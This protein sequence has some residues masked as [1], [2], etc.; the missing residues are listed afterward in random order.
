VTGADPRRLPRTK[1]LFIGGEGRSGSTVLERLLATDPQTCAV[2][3]AKYLFERGIGSGELCGCGRPVPECELWSVVGDRLVGG[4]GSPEG[5]DLVQF[6]TALD[7]PRN[8]PAVVLGRGAR[9]RR[10]RAVL[11]ELYPLIAEVSGCE[12]IID[13]SKHPAWAYLLAGTDTVDLRVVHLVRHPSGVVQSWS[14]SVKRPQ[15]DKGSGDQLMA[16]QSPVEVALR[17]DIFNRLYHRLGRRSVPTVLVR[18]EDY[19]NDLEGTL[20][21]CF[22]LFGLPYMSAPDGM[23]NGHGIAGNPSRFAR[24][25]EKITQDDR[26][27]TELGGNTHRIVSALTWRTRSVYGYRSSRTS[28]VRPM[29]RHAPGYIVETASQ[30]EPT[31]PVA[32]EADA[33]VSASPSSQAD[34]SS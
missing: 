2:G 19:V 34:S 5:I 3:E 27:V 23:A 8:L 26:W 33:V 29:V 24:G 20:R 11:S 28:P 32:A 15:A 10:A 25:D 1:V 30:P 14:R 7:S 31:E 12:V 9:V 4:W 13:S 18:Y 16:A 17:W 6:F 21:A 22:G